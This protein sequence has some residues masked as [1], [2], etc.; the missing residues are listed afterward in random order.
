MFR[1]ALLGLSWRIANFLTRTMG[2]YDV[3]FALQ[4]LMFRL[5]LLG[6]SWRIAN[7]LTRTMG[8]LSW[9]ILRPSYFIQ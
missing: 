2:M 3:P 9:P 5:A 8:M 7:F 1:L 4:R 6:L